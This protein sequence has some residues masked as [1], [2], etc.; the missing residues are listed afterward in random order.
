MLVQPHQPASRHAFGTDH[1]RIRSEIGPAQIL[2]IT[3]LRHEF[4]IAAAAAP[5]FSVRCG[6]CRSPGNGRPIPE[7]RVESGCTPF[8]RRGS[9][10]RP[11]A[12]SIDV[13]RQHIGEPACAVHRLG[14]QSLGG[15][16]EPPISQRVEHP[17]TFAEAGRSAKR[18]GVVHGHQLPPLKIGAVPSKF[19]SSDPRPG[20]FGSLDL[21]RIPCR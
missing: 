21:L 15:S 4:A 19:R 7:V 1:G 14:D 8:Q 13:D 20:R 17:V 10:R 18:S 2:M 9:A 3:T 6:R 5:M 12:T 11:P 16:R